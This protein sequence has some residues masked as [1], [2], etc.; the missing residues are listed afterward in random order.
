VFSLGVRYGQVENVVCHVAKV[1][2]WKVFRH[3]GA[4][5]PD[6]S[7]QVTVS[8]LL[9]VIAEHPNPAETLFNNRG[10]GNPSARRVPKILKAELVRRFAETLAK[11]NVESFQSFTAHQNG[12]ALDSRLCALPALSSGVGV[13]YFRML[14]GDDQQVKPDRMILRF[15]E[16]VVSKMD[17]DSAANLIQKTS[18]IL[19][20]RYPA[21]TPRLLDHEIWK[22]QRQ[23]KKSEDD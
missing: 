13:R 6:V 18:A 19:N 9:G 1:T 21:L 20:A 12:P 23:Q 22:F 11:N 14:A 7:G 5:F 16:D 10:N 3:H 15:I 2:G 17:V 4:E 8:D